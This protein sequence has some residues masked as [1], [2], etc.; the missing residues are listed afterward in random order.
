[1]AEHLGPR[2][3]NRRELLAGA[4]TGIL[5]IYLVG[6]GGSSSKLPVTTAGTAP[7]PRSRCDDGRRRASA[8]ACP[9]RRPRAAR[10]AA[11]WS[12]SGRRRATRTT[13]RSATPAPAGTRSA[14]SRTRRCTRTARTT[15]RSRSARATCRRSR[16][17]ASR[18]RS[19]CATAWLPQ[20]PAGGGRRLRCTPGTG[21]STRRTRAGRPAT[22]TRSRAPRSA[23]RTARRPSPASRWSIRQTLQVTLVQPDVTFL[24]ALT[25]P[26]M[27]PVPKEE[28]E[29]YGKD[30]QA[31]VVGNGPYKLTT[32]DPGGQTMLFDKHTA[33]HWPGLP[34]VDQ[35]EYRWGV[36]PGVQI[37][38]L[39]EGRGGRARR[40][41]RRAATWR[42]CGATRSSRT[43]SSS[44]RCSRSAG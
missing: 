11:S 29:K 37:L 25:Q 3:L 9:G 20:R 42:R 33:Y 24:Y 31:H 27:A 1:M 43:T 18:T 17:T 32:Y 10:R 7:P 4:G 21:C 15:T 34:Y 38:E 8:S 13:R 14:T 44:S 36:D 35:V 41:P 19:R 12:S 28:V 39:S 6:C 5:A 30:F 2:P 26:F 22:S 23:T 40:R 16:P